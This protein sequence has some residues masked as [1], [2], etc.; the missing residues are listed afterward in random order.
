MQT[1]NMNSRITF[2]NYKSGQNDDGEV[3]AK[4]EKNT[5]FKCWSE[6]SKATLKEFKERTQSA[7]MGNLRKR[8]DTRVFAIRYQQKKEVETTMLIEFRGR[9]YR[10]IDVEEDFK[11]KDMLLVKAEAVV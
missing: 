3:T 1:R 8:K 6:V 11:F 4:K 7:D 2:F 9:D 10:I 5:H